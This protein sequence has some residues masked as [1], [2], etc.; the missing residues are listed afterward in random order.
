MGIF[1][2]VKS[3]VREMM[4][5]RPD[6]AKHLIV[7]KHPDQNI[8][9]WSQLTVD[10]DE[11]ALFFKDGRYVGYLPTGRHTLQTQNIPF[12]NNLV[13]RLTGGDVFIA[14]I[15]FVKTQPVRGVPFGGPLESMEDPVLY[16][17]VTPRIFGEFSLVVVDPVRFVVGYHGQCGGSGDN[18]VILGWIKGKFFMSVKSVIGQ[19]CAQQQKSLLNLGGMSMELGARIVQ[20]APNLEEIGCKILEIGN[21]NINFSAEDQRLLREA[22]KARGEARRGIGIAQD[23]ARAKQFELD[24]RFQQ[25]ARYVQQLAGNWQ[26][27]AAGQAMMGAGEGMA[28]GGD[29]GGVAALGAQVAIGAGLAQGMNPALAG[30][31]QPQFVPPHL[32]HPGAPQG[33]YPGAPQGGYPGAPQ[34]GYPGAPQGGYPGA[35]QAAPAAGPTIEQ[36]LE[37]LADLKNK[38]LITDE[39]FQARKAK[40]LEEI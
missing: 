12:L 18:D 1:D 23:A 26:N 20:S 21:F 30:Q 5:A 3:G 31:G 17:F 6:T 2:F 15:F 10:S 28:K 8:P 9:F 37:R 16:E 29:G 35:P 34:G 11:C 36:R 39:E 38:G 25:D 33:G 14:E 13:N 19:V 24:Q 27:Y 32:Q 40:I 4:I 7:Y 22:N